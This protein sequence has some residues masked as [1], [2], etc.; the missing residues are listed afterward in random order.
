MKKWLII[1]TLGISLGSAGLTPLGAQSA[2]APE[3]TTPGWAVSGTQRT[4]RKRSG[5][6]MMILFISAL[7]LI[8][9]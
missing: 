3:S 9:R 2:G 7:N 4:K 6:E 5:M 1:L 8:R